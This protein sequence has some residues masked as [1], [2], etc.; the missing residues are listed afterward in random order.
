[1]AQ[2]EFGLGPGRD[3]VVVVAALDDADIRGDAGV[4]IGQRVQP[5]DLA[6][7]RLDRAG[8]VLVG[9]AGMRGAPGHSDVERA[10]AL[11]AG[12]DV[13]ADAPRFGVE[14]GAGAARGVLDLGAAFRRADLFVG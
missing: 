6:R 12:D 7:E 2:I 1:E 11:A 14:H 10:A 9:D 4:V 8:A 5:H 3:R 13:A